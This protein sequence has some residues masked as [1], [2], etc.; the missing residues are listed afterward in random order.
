MIVA[1]SATGYVLPCWLY[2]LSQLASSKSNRR[3]PTAEGLFY[4]FTG[5]MRIASPILISSIH[6]GRNHVLN[7]LG[8]LY[9]REKIEVILVV[10]TKGKFLN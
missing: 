5:I 10:V 2:C 4:N 8:G 9:Q 1:A 7:G 6:Q 3:V